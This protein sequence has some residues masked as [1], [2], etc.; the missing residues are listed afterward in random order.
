M[1]F[2]NKEHEVRFLKIKEQMPEQFYNDRER[3]TL[4]YLMAGNQEL[5]R[6]IERYLDWKG[7]FSFN[8]M[9]EKEDFSAGIKVLAKLAVVLYNDGVSLE[10]KELYCYLDKMNLQLALNAA[11]YR[12]NRTQV[13]IYD[14]TDTNSILK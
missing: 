11:D 5:Q 12:Y 13:G 14:I 10:F 3:L 6:K 8:E 7:G 2:L 1:K 9:F 4:V